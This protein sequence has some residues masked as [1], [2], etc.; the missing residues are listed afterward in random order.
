MSYDYACSG[1]ARLETT[2][3]AWPPN[4]CIKC[5]GSFRPVPERILL[6]R[7]SAPRIDGL[8]GVNWRS[9]PWWGWCILVFLLMVVGNVFG[10]AG[11]PCIEIDLTMLGKASETVCTDSKG[12]VYS[13]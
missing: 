6:P 8:Q 12:G 5:L 4:Y 11:D 2:A 9:M 13:P 10:G 3:S 1:C 7:P